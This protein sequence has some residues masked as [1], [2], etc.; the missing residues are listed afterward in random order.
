MKITVLFDPEDGT[1]PSTKTYS[2]WSGMVETP[3][4]L[5]LGL[6]KTTKELIHD[7]Q[8]KKAGKPTWEDKEARLAWKAKANEWTEP[9]DAMIEATKRL[10]KVIDI[11]ESNFGYGD[12]RTWSR[13]SREVWHAWV[14]RETGTPHPIEECDCNDLP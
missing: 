1:G 2:L 7:W 6:V 9:I 13:K 3:G 10:V 5:W 11:E 8:W 4:L 14:T 12:H